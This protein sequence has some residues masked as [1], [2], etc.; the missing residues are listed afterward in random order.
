M[1][2]GN[3]RLPGALEE[4]EH[5]GGSAGGDDDLVR[6]DGAGVLG[7]EGEE[8]GGGVPAGV[9]EQGGFHGGGQ[10]L[11]REG[12]RKEGRGVSE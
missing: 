11:G 1:R 7:G 6:E 3:Q 12:G 10:A 5:P 9:L 4:G 2:E 8:R